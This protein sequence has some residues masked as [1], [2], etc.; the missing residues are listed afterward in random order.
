MKL[1]KV[2]EQSDD[3]R[4]CHDLGRMSTNGDLPHL[5]EKEGGAS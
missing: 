1:L 2:G 4:S 5:S 3:V